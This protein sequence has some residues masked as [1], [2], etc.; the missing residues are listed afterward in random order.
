VRS[1]LT[2]L[3]LVVASLAVTLGLVE[4]ALRL[5]P[6]WSRAGAPDERAVFNPYRP[7]GRLGFTLNPGARVRHTNRD[8]SVAVAVNALGLR[9]AERA[10]ARRPGTARILL[11]GDSFAFGWGVEQEDTFGAWIERLLAARGEPVEIWSA[12][13]PGWSTDQH[14]LYLHIRG[15]ALD[16]DLVVLAAGENDLEELAF[17]RLTLDAS[18]LPVRIE[19]LWR[20]IDATGRMRYVGE[21]R[22]ALPRDD[23]PGEGWLRDHSRLYHWLRFR[24]AKLTV[25]MAVRRARPPAPAWLAS[26][27]GRPIGAL[28]PDDLQRALAT[29]REFRLRYHAFLVSAMEEAARAR[30]IPLR[31]LLV[32]HGGEA[33]PA[34]PVLAG[35]HAACRARRAVCFDSAEVITAAETAR[36]TFAH[37]SHWNPAG[38]RRIGEALAA[39]LGAEPA[40]GRA[41]SGGAGP[42]WSSGRAAIAPPISRTHLCLV[43]CD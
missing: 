41:R 10:V 34:D 9:G 3:G 30:G 17:N 4:A 6:A 21:S 33:Q 39:W 36:F 22:G 8:F 14:Y 25:L 29:S 20:M 28:A 35:L 5:G 42:P 13:V 31:T 23:W 2:R 19:P 37:D 24:L 43:F 11:L 40:L 32:A 1:L 12:A 27:P 7:D 15:L 26:D 38:H 18:R 16:P